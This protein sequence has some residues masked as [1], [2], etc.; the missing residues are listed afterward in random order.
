MHD[1]DSVD[2]IPVLG[3]FLVLFS[4]GKGVLR[5]CRNFGETQREDGVDEVHKSLSNSVLWMEYNAKQCSV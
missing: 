1:V 5:V 4:L 2:H 3:L